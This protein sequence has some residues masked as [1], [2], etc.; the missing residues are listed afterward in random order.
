MKNITKFLSLLLCLAYMNIIKAQDN[1][2][3]GYIITNELDTLYG[4]INNKAYSINAKKCEFKENTNKKATVYYPND[5]LGY[6]FENGKYYL[7]KNVNLKGK[8]TILFLEYLIDGE[9]DVYFLQ[10]KNQQ[11]HYY[12]S[13]GNEEL[14]ELIYK[15]EIISKNG[16]SYEKEH[17]YYVGVLKY[18]TS[19]CSSLENEIE[20]IKKPT[21]KKLIKFSEKYHNMVCKGQKC[22]IYEKNIPFIF[23]V[24]LVG[25]MK[26][27]KNKLND[28]S[29]I[30]HNLYGLNFYINNPRF[31]EKWHFGIG[32]INEAKLKVD[33]LGSTYN[34]IKI[35]L[36]YN[37]MHPKNGFSPTFSAGI[38]IVN[39]D[40]SLG[41]TLSITPGIKLGFNNLHVKVFTEMEFLAHGIIPRRYFATNIGVCLGISLK[42]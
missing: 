6:R 29:N 42:K 14:K 17:F 12:V 18:F 11:N 40:K 3:K 1:Y 37:Y 4:E 24:N 36:T 21:H 28:H 33:S 22:I 23:T 2:Q 13:K 31:S 34:Y 27:F 19:D 9:L 5:I 38:N 15:T 10:S 16:K 7:S 35:P 32:Y 25:G 39:I 41:T 30:E 20:T 26:F 8:D